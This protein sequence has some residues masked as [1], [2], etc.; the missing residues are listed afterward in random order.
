MSKIVSTDLQFAG[1]KTVTNIPAST[2]SGQA[3][4]HDQLATAITNN[5]LTIAGVDASVLSIVAGE[6]F[7]D[8]QAI[9]DSYAVT[10]DYT[11]FDASSSFAAISNG[12]NV[13][14]ILER[15]DGNQK[16]LISRSNASVSKASFASV[17]LVA[18]TAYDLVHGFTDS[19]IVDAI[20]DTSTGESVIAGFDHDTGVVGTSTVT[21]SVTGTYSIKLV[22]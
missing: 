16:E 1:G 15:L 11:S 22:W 2:A 8:E 14:W 18:D 12:E 6:L 21:V 13:E 20:I 9:N 3:V 5:Q 19:L 7:I 10:G 17:S 4:E